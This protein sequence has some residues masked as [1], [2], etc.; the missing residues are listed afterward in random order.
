MVACFLEAEGRM[1]GG[2]AWE[3][4]IAHERHTPVV[5]IARPGDP[6]REH[7]ILRQSAGYVLDSLEQGVRI[8]RHLLLPGL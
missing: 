5:M 6:H 3:M 1:S 7:V 8:V 4:G 2:T